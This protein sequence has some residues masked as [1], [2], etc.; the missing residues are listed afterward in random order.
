M[1]H[2]KPVIVARKSFRN[3]NSEL[4]ATTLYTPD[5]DGLFRASVYLE[6]GNDDPG[7]GARFSLVWTDDFRN[8]EPEGSALAIQGGAVGSEGPIGTTVLRAK[9]NTPITFKVVA[10]LDEGAV[11]ATPYNVFVVLEEL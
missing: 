4:S 3:L 9:R 11:L 1:E 6:T 7:T 10:G 8:Q 5:E 2:N